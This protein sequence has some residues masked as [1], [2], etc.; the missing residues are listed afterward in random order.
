MNRN[1]AGHFQESLSLIPHQEV[2]FLLEDD[3]AR[4]W[5][6]K[7][8]AENLA[9]WMTRLKVRQPP[10]HMPK[11]HV[12]TKKKTSFSSATKSLRFLCLCRPAYSILICSS[13][14]TLQILM[15]TSYSGILSCEYWL[16]IV[17]LLSANECLFLNL[18]ILKDKYVTPFLFF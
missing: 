5:W 13:Y 18:L 15:P 3:N 8:K 1:A 11:T 2:S 6:S 17:L 10:E 7:K 12:R 9:S 4:R 16:S 14:P